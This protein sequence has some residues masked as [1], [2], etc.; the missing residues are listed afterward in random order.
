MVFVDH[1]CFLNRGPGGPISGPGAT[2]DDCVKFTPG[3]V[4]ACPHHVKD[5]R[6]HKGG[7]VRGVHVHSTPPAHRA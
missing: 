4:I 6:S 7:A 5:A 2:P 3:R 1:A